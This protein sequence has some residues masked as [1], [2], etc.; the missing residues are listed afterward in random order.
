MAS[1][2]AL[3]IVPDFFNHL[4]RSPWE[5]PF[6]KVNISA[7]ANFD[8]YETNSSGRRINRLV[9]KDKALTLGKLTNANLTMSTSLRGGNGSGS[10]RSAVVPGQ[11]GVNPATGVPYSQENEAESEMIRRNP[12]DYIDFNSP[13]TLGLSY[14]LGYSVYGTQKNLTQN[15]SMNGSLGLT[16]KWQLG[17]NSYY[18]I[19]SQ[20]LGGVT[21]NI[22]RDLHCWG[23]SVAVS[24]INPKYFTITISP[25]SELLRDLKINRTR[26][27]Y[28]Y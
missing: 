12:A 18:N 11:S 16:P 14:T 8:P 13:W 2:A 20:Q 10:K 4:D 1:A 24:P 17:F 9:W 21:L 25:R 28:N 7:G 5:I 19:T 15:V 23:L 3:K 6:K 22:T 26:Y 27:F